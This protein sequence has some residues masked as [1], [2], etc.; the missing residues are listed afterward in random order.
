MGFQSGEPTGDKPIGLSHVA[1]VTADLDAFRTFYEQTIGL[2]TTVVLGPGRDHARQAVVFAGDVMLHVFEVPGFDPRV[3]GSASTML[4]RGRLD[5][6]GFTVADEAALVA[7]RD[8]LLAVGASS[9]LIRRLGPMLSVRFEDAEGF[10]GEVNCF[11]PEYDPSTVRDEDEVLAPDWL[12]R[13]RR[14]MRS[15]TRGP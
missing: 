11:D 5:H 12:D 4:Q 13:T 15:D 10:E 14:V 7:V 6:L 2:E 1:V 3:F 9:G 8:R